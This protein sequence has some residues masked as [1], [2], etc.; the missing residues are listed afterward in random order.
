MTGEP[1]PRERE[2]LKFIETHRTAYGH[3]PSCAQMGLG[4]GFTKTRAVQ[5]L[6]ALVDKGLVE[7]QSGVHRSAR[8][9]SAGLKAIGVRAKKAA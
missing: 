5:I 4:L 3:T 2:L 7:H 9:T 8:L 6:G 1:T